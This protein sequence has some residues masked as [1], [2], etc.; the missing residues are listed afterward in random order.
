MTV[1][2]H[3]GDGFDDLVIAA[4]MDK[5]NSPERPG[6][7]YVFP[8]PLAAG[9][10]DPA[11]DAAVVYEDDAMLV[12]L[13]YAVDGCDLDGDGDEEI[14]V[15]SPGWGADPVYP[16]AAKVA[17]PIRAG[18]VQVIEGGPWHSASSRR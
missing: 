3:D 4:S 16:S 9:P 11:T 2:D 5:Y 8:G 15:G 12:S 18:R 14:I 13:G 7:L 17:Q 1:L 10:L 6:L